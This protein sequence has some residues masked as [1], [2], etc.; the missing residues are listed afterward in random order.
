[1]RLFR[2]LFLLPLLLLSVRADEYDDLRNRWLDMLTGGSSLDLDDSSVAS[3]ITSITNAAIAQRDSINRSTGRTNLWSDAASTTVSAD[4]TTNYTRI[5]TMAIAYATRGSTLQG[6]TSLRDDILGAL[7]WMQ[8]NR[9]NAT[10]TAYNNWWD[11]EIGSPQKLN[12]ILVLMYA[13]LGAT[14]LANNL[15]T[16]D[17][18]APYQSW[19]TGANRSDKCLVVAIRGIIGKTA[20]K[21]VDARDQLSPVFPYVTSSDG[22]Y[23]DGSFIQHSYHPYTGS[24]GAELIK[25]VSYLYALLANSTWQITDP[26]C[27]NVFRWVTEGFAPLYQNGAMM[28]MVRGRAVSR[29]GDDHG[30]GAYILG[31]ILR[32]A[33][34]AP[35]AKGRPIMAFVKGQIAADTYR[36]YVS[37]VPLAQ[38]AE[39]HALLADSSLGG[40][41]QS[42]A[43]VRFPSM[44][45]VVHRRPGWAFGLAMSSARIATYESINSENLKGWFTGDGMLTLYNSDLGQY[46]DGWRPTIDPYHF[47]GVTADTATRTNASSQSVRPSPTW[48]GEVSSANMVRPECSLPEPPTAWSAG[49]PGFSSTMRSSASAQASLR[50][51]AALSTRRSR[52]ESSAV[53]ETNASRSTEATKRPAWAGVEPSPQPHGVRWLEPVVTTS[54]PAPR[55]RPNAKPG[56]MPGA[57]STPVNPRPASRGIS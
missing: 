15:A 21:L 38:L 44:D 8:A 49:N 20:S 35:S 19:M 50:E 37:G 10:K 47:P 27:D 52:T 45:R 7:D 4:I 30:T 34:A 25:G 16:L 55:S 31:S 2:T 42:V 3:R 11:W 29:N 36:N 18:W 57:R 5:R 13:D 6:N 1:M 28:D 43:H 51:A 12:D 41:N 39:T 23:A 26:A 48:V 17:K 33:R 40:T 32:F 56:P 14:R 22:F 54:R 46:G 53:P 24:Y 9:Y